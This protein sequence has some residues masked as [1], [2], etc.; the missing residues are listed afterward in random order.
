MAEDKKL[1][2]EDL[3]ME[4]EDNNTNEKVTVTVT[5]TNQIDS[6]QPPI[7]SMS[8]SSPITDG[9]VVN[10]KDTKPKKHIITPND[11]NEVNDADA[12]PAPTPKNG[13]G[14][15]VGDSEHK[16][17]QITNVNQFLGR[18]PKPKEDPIRK[19]LDNLYKKADENIERVKKDLSRPGGVID[20]GKRKYIAFK[21]PKLE[22]RA[23]TNPRLQNQIK[24][25]NDIIDTDP[26]FD[27]ITDYERKAYILFVIAR[28]ESIGVNN[29]YFGIE[30]KS[31]NNA[32]R[33]SNDNMK[34]I[35][36]IIEENNNL[37]IDFDNEDDDML[38]LG[39]NV[40]T[41]ETPRFND[42]N[43]AVSSSDKPNKVEIASNDEEEEKTTTIIPNADDANVEKDKTDSD[44][45]FLTEDIDD[46]SESEDD[47]DDDIGVSE[48]QLKKNREEFRND[49]VQ[50]LRLNRT[51]DLEGFVVSTKPISLKAAIKP[52]QVSSFSYTWPLL[53]TGV[54]AEITPLAGDEI[55]NLN[56][57]NTNF[58]TVRGLNTVFS[59]LYHHI[60]NQNKAPFETWLR[61]TS[62]Y[63]IDN[64]IFG[65]HAA[66]FKDSNYVTYECSN[67]KCKHIFLRKVDIMDMVTFPN[68]ETKKRFN[69]ILDSDG[70]MSQTY[71]ST[72]KRIN[73]DYA[74]GFVSQSIYSNLFEPASLSAEFT[75]KY[76]PIISLMP[77]IDKIYRI[78][79]TTKSLYPIDFG[80]VEKSLSKTVQRKVRSIYTIL[81]SFTPDERSI[82][83]AE[84]Q[85]IANQMDK[86][87][88]TYSIPETKCPVCGQKIE[89]QESNPLN[90]LFTRAQ[91][92]I[93]AAYIQE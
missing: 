57:Q 85:K 28:D 89:K 79:N 21:Y 24:K 16:Y 36:S 81:Q 77:N 78:D 45:I 49:L 71:K 52:K 56:P 50:K 39:A 41:I 58:E 18:K 14:E 25:I 91:L 26:R 32:P 17:T 42:I 64:I 11:K 65:A 12:K 1:S 3:G 23:K 19:T 70:V 72:P 31:D 30:E 84:A 44:T 68:D 51:D 47:E 76:G 74:I 27:G 10:Y 83:V 54:G 60:I 20:E 4:K 7:D 48:E 35:D 2:L 88:V 5:P 15:I 34:F 37:G 90:I 53:Y 46:D 61:Q 8:V 86:W 69:D 62:D 59:I 73:N 13:A 67:K 87:K 80:V 29:E 82:V 22:A 6:N 43:T 63:D 75:K 93:V 92:P 40:N 9:P 55:I 66:T 33:S 38:S